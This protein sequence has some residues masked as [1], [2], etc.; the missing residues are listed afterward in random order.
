MAH[1]KKCDLC[2]AMDKSVETYR[3]HWGVTG[4]KRSSGIGK[5]MAS[6]CQVLLDVLLPVSIW[7]KEV[8]LRCFTVN[9]VVPLVMPI[10]MDLLRP[11]RPECVPGFIQ[12]VVVEEEAQPEL[13]A[14]ETQQLLT[15]LSRKLLKA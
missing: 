6:D 2:G 11:Y 10:L 15:L 14:A 13:S 3:R 9:I 8:C 5:T 7:D 12:G 1:V 4:S